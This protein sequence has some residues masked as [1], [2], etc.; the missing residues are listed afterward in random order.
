MSLRGYCCR[1][2]DQIRCY[3]NTRLYCFT[4]SNEA[5]KFYYCYGV[6]RINSE[7]KTCFLEHQ[8]S[9]SQYFCWLLW[10]SIFHTLL[11]LLDL[12]CP[13]FL[14]VPLIPPYIFLVD[15]LN[16]YDKRLVIKISLTGHIHAYHRQLKK[17][18][19]LCKKNPSL[20]KSVNSYS[21]YETLLLK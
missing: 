14:P 19:I 21:I 9:I 2:H 1:K 10:L 18:I 5:K 12:F 6:F 20:T 4:C 13:W 16:G 17:G 15:C 8:C 3:K 11:Y 7:T